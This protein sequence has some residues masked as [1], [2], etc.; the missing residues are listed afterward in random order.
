MKAVQRMSKCF[1]MSKR[2]STDLEDEPPS[3]VDT[4]HWLKTI[5]KAR[6]EGRLCIPSWN[7]PS[8][9]ECGKDGNK[10]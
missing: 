4:A 2:I 7:R 9:R 10:G 6:G 3:K 8:N 1:E 5:G